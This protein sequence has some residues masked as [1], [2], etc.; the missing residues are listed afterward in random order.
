LKEHF[1]VNRLSEINQAFQTENFIIKNPK[2]MAAVAI[3]QDAVSQAIDDMSTIC[4]YITLHFPKMEDGNNFGVSVQ[5]TALKQLQETTDALTKV[6]EDLSKYYTARADAMDK[7]QLAS[8]TAS[9]TQ[10]EENDGST[11]KKTTTKE[12]KKS[13]GLQ[14][15]HRV[16]AVY[17]VDTHFYF[18]SKKALRSVRSAYVANIDFLMKNKEKIELPRGTERGSIRSMY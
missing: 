9:E 6:L 16:Q 2:L 8:E 10:K 7:L 3:S 13:S 1:A 11:N 12:L 5:M 17:A 4:D 18:L 15:F 14:E